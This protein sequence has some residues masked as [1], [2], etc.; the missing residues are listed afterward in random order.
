MLYGMGDVDT[1]EASRRSR[2]LS[3]VLAAR[4]V[5]PGAALALMGNLATSTAE[6]KARWWALVMWTVTDLLIALA[7]AI[8][9]RT[10]RRDQG[11]L[12]EPSERSTTTGSRPNRPAVHLAA[13][14]NAAARY[15][16][17]RI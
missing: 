1:R 16:S 17:G 4:L 2:G 11:G 10:D 5:L 9:I 15:T 14:G 13:Y 6:V 7:V 3:V 8:E 12:P